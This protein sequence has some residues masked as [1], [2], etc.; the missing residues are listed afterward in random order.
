MESEKT[1]RDKQIETLNGDIAKQ[2]ESIAK[3]GKEKKHVEDSLAERTE[4]LQAAEDK[5]NQLNKAKGKL[6]SQVKEVSLF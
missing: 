4:Q 2:D 1:N 3:L 6:E 5:A